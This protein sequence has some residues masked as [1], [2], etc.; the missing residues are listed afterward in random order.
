MTR[1]SALFLITDVVAT[2]TQAMHE[3]DGRALAT[4]FHPN[5]QIVGRFDGVLEWDG[6]E[7]FIAA[8]EGAAGTSRDKL[9][10]YEIHSLDVSGD[11]AVVRVA[12]VWGGLDFFDTLSLVRHEGRWLIATRM[13]THLG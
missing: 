2:Y 6:L 4:V 10:P 1:Q 5:A 12:I 7:A 3:G 8:C 11:T 9:P 13:F